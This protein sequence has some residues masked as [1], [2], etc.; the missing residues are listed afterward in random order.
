MLKENPKLIGEIDTES[1]MTPLQYASFSGLSEL[2]EA[3]IRAHAAP[4]DEPE[5]ENGFTPL[6]LAC[7]SGHKQAVERLLLAGANANLQSKKGRET[8]MHMLAGRGGEVPMQLVRLL[9]PFAREALGMRDEKGRLPWEGCGS[10]TE[11][12]EVMRQNGEESREEAEVSKQSV[13]GRGVERL[14]KKVS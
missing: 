6:M 3:L 1:K 7:R 2:I 13:D 4:F 10:L 11:M 8:V 5:P 14:M 12:A 9:M